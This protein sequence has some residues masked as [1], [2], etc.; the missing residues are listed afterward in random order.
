M[1]H[2]I[3]PSLSGLAVPGNSKAEG[4]AAEQVLRQGWDRNK[5]KTSPAQL[6]WSCSP[7]QD[8]KDVN[9]HLTQPQFMDPDKELVQE[10]V[11]LLQLWN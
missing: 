11:R 3:V 8:T 5:T 9:N 2:E 10:Q 6:D 7:E 1:E 4:G